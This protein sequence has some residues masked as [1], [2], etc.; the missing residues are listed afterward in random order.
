MDTYFIFRYFLLL[1]ISSVYRSYEVQYFL[2][3][4]PCFDAA[5]PDYRLPI[6]DYRL[7]ITDYRLPI[8]D[9]RLP[10]TDYRLPITDYRLPI[11]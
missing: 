4:I 2:T 10:I 5:H 3:L 7:P 9:Y 6:T 11:T 1:T 8:T